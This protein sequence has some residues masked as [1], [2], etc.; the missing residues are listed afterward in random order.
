MERAVWMSVRILL[1]SC[2]VNNNMYL[3]IYFINDEPYI[4]LWNVKATMFN[5]CCTMKD[6][7]NPK[8][9]QKWEELEGV[10]LI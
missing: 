8:W 9:Q 7:N 6:K 4:C 10:H 5:Y 3:W 2:Y 1:Y